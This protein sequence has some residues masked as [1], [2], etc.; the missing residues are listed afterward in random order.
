MRWT[1]HSVR[2]SI[3]YWADEIKDLKNEG[4]N[5]EPPSIEQDGSINE[6]D[7]WESPVL[8]KWGSSG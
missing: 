4:M 3:Q 7:G 6:I 1:Y 8:E 2:G 5:V